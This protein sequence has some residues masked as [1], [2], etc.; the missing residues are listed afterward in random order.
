MHEHNTTSGETTEQDIDQARER[1]KVNLEMSV[2]LSGML[3]NE[4]SAYR[5]ALY[6]ELFIDAQKRATKIK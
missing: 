1:A 2:F 5:R 6:K 4:H 3:N